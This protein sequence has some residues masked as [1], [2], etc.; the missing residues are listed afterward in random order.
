MVSL[1]IGQTFVFSQSNNNFLSNT[2]TLH[3]FRSRYMNVDFKFIDPEKGYFGMDYTINLKR[4]FRTIANDTIFK[5][6]ISLNLNSTGFVTVRGKS[7]AQNSIINELNFEW[8]PIFKQKKNPNIVISI[9]KELE[10]SDEEII[11]RIM[12][13]ASMLQ[14]PLWLM[15]NIHGKH[16]TTQD[17]KNYDIAVGGSMT[18]TTS[19][20]NRILDLPF[21]ILRSKAHNHPRH[22]DLNL[23]FDYVTKLDKTESANLRSKNNAN[24]LN[25]NAEWETGLFERERITFLY[26]SFH[27]LSPTTA[28]KDA[29][30]DNNFFYMIKLEHP[31]GNSKDGIRKTVS[32]KYLQGALPPNFNKG[33]VLGGGFSMEF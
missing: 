7:N 18:L 8:S 31:I 15:F 21:A 6:N 26:S 29:K 16:E 27:E 33:F 5:P 28:I 3:L 32:I 24:R 4:E 30:M 12:K 13:Q 19:Y 9:E 2:D 22:L 1:L 14:S 25:F 11:E 10:K 20:L 17:F 23:S